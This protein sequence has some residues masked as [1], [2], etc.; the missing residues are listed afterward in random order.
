MVNRIHTPDLDSDLTGHASKTEMNVIATMVDSRLM[1]TGRLDA[2]NCDF[3]VRK[4]EGSLMQ[5]EL[6]WMSG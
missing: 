1:L 3:C 4:E 5:I 6:N 2:T